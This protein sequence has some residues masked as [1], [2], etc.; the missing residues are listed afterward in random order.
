MKKLVVVIFTMLLALNLT[1]IEI[2]TNDL[3]VLGGTDFS[4]KDKIGNFNSIIPGLTYE[5]EGGVNEKL[6]LFLESELGFSLSTTS[7][8]GNYADYSEKVIYLGINPS[9]EYSIFENSTFALAL[10]YA[11]ENI[12]PAA[13]DSEFEM[14]NS[15]NLESGVDYSTLEEDI[16]GTSP[17]AS[18]EEGYSIALQFGMGL[19]EKVGDETVEDKDMTIETELAYSYF[20]KK[21]LF[22]IKPFLVLAK[23]LNEKVS[24][25]LEIE[26]GLTFN[27]DLGKLF[28]TE[29]TFAVISEKENSDA[30][31]VNGFDL[32]LSLLYYPIDEL[33]L[34][35]FTG[36]DKDDFSESDEKI[37]IKYGI[38]LD[39]EIFAK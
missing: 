4:N 6:T 7:F 26:T 22:M 17:W 15:L 18:F 33:E 29:L 11:I 12:S 13:E 20:N 34:S 1:A 25:S 24:E 27:N 23:H 38:A 37:N 32:N 14:V 5:F 8:D 21:N 16:E 30:D 3:H 35:I 36:F 19:F 31:F 10:P 2:E 28:S 9:L 39:F